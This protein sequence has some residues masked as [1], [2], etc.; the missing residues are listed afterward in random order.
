MNKLWIALSVLVIALGSAMILRYQQP[1]PTARPFI[2]LAQLINSEAEGFAPV[3]PGWQY[4]FPNDHGAHPDFRMDAWYFTGH[5][6]TTQ[7]QHFGFQMTFVRVA[8]APEKPDIDS[9]WAFNE[10]YRAHVAITDIGHKQFHASE[11][12]SRAALGLAGAA[13]TPVRVWLDNWEM[14]MPDQTQPHFQLR[15][16][17]E[18]IRLTLDLESVKQAIT[19]VDTGTGNPHFHGYWLPRLQ[20]SGV[21]EVSRGAFTVN[22]SATLNHVW[23]GMSL[24]RGQLSLNR[25]VLQ[26]DDNRDILLF[27]LRRR[28]GSAEPISTGLLIAP[29]GA[30]R[31][32]RRQDLTIDVLDQWQSAE[33]G[34]R[35][36][37]RWRLQIPKED[38]ELDIIPMLEN[39]ELNLSV[40]YW[41]GVV[42]I[43]GK[44]AGQ[45]VSGTGQVELTAYAPDASQ[46]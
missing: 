35:Y 21:L 7:G 40:R 8:L 13:Q 12:F 6:T 19:N 42:R 33:G 15:A 38:L 43:T 11:R 9:A 16:V 30:I 24:Y 2:P 41:A 20:T 18:E 45:V 37:S 10:I 17:A 34:V 23:G 25:F 4:V 29:G 36:P 31:Q 14:R 44:S 5:L 26:L 22:G 32:L 3:K 1:S 39:Q 28:D 46:L 27:Q